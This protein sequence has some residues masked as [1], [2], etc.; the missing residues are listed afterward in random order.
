MNALLLAG[1]PEQQAQWLPHLMNGGIASL[2]YTGSL[3]SDHGGQWDAQA[4]TATAVRQ[5]ADWI[6]DG[7]YRY[8]VDA[9]SAELLIIAAREPVPLGEASVRLFVVPVNTTGVSITT[10]PTLDQT[11]RWGS[12][13]LRDVTLSDAALMA[14]DA[15]AA[16]LLD[17][18]LDL[19]RIALAAEQMGGAQRCLDMAV[20]YAKERVQFNRPIAGFQAIKHK[21]ADMMLRSEVARSSAYYAACVAQQVREQL[22]QGQPPDNASLREAASIAKA[23]CSEAFFA[24]AAEALQIHGGVGF[25]WE[26]DVHLFFKRAKV[27][28]HYLGTPAWL[29][30]RLAVQ[31]LDGDVGESSEGA[32]A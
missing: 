18:I 22:A 11:R 15:D 32:L 19:A 24:N 6:L 30:E 27:S 25:T 13:T 12:V 20:D 21:A 7:D 9:V 4:I 3:A 28:E 10:L 5:G 16:M 26:Y 2:A 23:Y 17:I 8:V 29:R 1:T 14:P 31:L